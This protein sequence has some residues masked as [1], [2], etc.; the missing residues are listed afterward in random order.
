MAKL[1]AF[2]SRADENYFGGNMKYIEVG[3]TEKAA[4]RFTPSAHMKVADFP[5]LSMIFKRPQRAQL[6]EKALPSTEAVWTV[7]NQHYKDGLRIM[8]SQLEIRQE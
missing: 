8:L 7:Q 3:N 5:A 6:W 4:K 2:Y 1:I